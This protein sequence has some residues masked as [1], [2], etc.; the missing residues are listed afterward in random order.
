MS[1]RRRRSVTVE[2]LVGTGNTQRPASLD[3]LPEP[4][5]VDPR[6]GALRRHPLDDERTLRLFLDRLRMGAHRSRAAESVGW[7]GDSVEQWLRR[8]RG[9]DSRGLPPTPRYV[10]FAKAVKRAEAE[11]EMMHVAN[12]VDGGARDWR[13]SWAFLQR[14]YPDRYGPEAGMEPP[15]TGALP[16][17][18]TFVYI[19]AR[20]VDAQARAHV[21]AHAIG[22]GDDTDYLDEDDGDGLELGVTDQPDPA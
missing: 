9:A 11:A 12:V 1:R 22:Q 8:G 21:I 13:A 10:G 5:D 7:S 16:P 3:V 19:D 6:G 14:R 17:S 15:A 20:T 18:Q 2:S 4:V